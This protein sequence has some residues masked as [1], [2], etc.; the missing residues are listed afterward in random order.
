MFAKLLIAPLFI[1]SSVVAAPTF[2]RRDVSL[3]DWPGQ[4][5]E[6]YWRFRMRYTSLDCASQNGTDFYNECCTPVPVG[7]SLPDDCTPT[8]CAA[9]SNSTIQ[10]TST[11]YDSSTDYDDSPTDSSTDYNDS[12][13]DS[14]TDYDDSPTDSYTDYDTPTPTP[15]DDD[16]PAPSSSQDDSQPT[17]TQAQDNGGSTGGSGNVNSGGYATYYYQNGNAGAC[18]NYHSD[19]DL[20]AAIDINWYENTGSQSPLCGQTV[21]ITNNNNGNSVDVIIADVCPTCAN[22]NSIDLS[23]AAFQVLASLDE[24]MVPISWSFE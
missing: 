15:T 1:A 16:D 24:G 23:V 10:S 2:V 6:S 8:T 14:Y 4:N 21:H 18:G 3:S 13:T 7:Q 12:P 20:I 22:G 19:N 11:E 5:L 9:P 17:T